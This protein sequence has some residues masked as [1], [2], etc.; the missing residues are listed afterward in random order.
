M[1]GKKGRKKQRKAGAK[2]KGRRGVYAAA[3]LDTEL[4]TVSTSGVHITYG[5]LLL[6]LRG[7][8]S[9]IMGAFAGLKRRFLDL[10]SA[11]WLDQESREQAFNES[12]APICNV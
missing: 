8:G 1:S 5:A 7:A 3:P 2:K 10:F 9:V 6:I 11:F 12:Q 4:V